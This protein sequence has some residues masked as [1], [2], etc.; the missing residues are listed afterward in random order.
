MTKIVYASD[1]HL[2]I[3][4]EI[5]PS[6]FKVEGDILVLAGDITCARFFQEYRNDADARM[7]EN[8]MNRFRDEIFPKFKQVIYLMGN[9]EH[10][11]FYI[12]ESARVLKS[13]FAKKGIPNLYFMDGDGIVVD[14]I[15]FVGGTLWTN[16]PNPLDAVYVENGMN[17]YKIIY[18]N[19]F[20]TASFEQ[21]QAAMARGSKYAIPLTVENTNVEHHMT[22]N[23]IQKYIELNRDKKIVVL[24]HHAP[25]FKS[26]S[27]E[28]SGSAL[29]PG[30]ATDL[31][32]FILTYEPDVWIHG[33]THN[34]LDY[35]IG[36]TRVLSSQPGYKN[37]E[38]SLWKNF[39]PG[40]IEI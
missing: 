4:R 9:H 35:E 13:F 20:T 25:S 22:M 11:G 3:S 36:K 15:L 2:E 39:T 30:Y 6:L 18:S 28:H 5:H 8:F 31:S 23:I 32:E 21:R 37:Y 19:D 40:V 16:I 27:K 12:H 10:Y 33:H 29:N 34:N 26:V 17:D 7:H 24:T 1:L 38:I 14:D